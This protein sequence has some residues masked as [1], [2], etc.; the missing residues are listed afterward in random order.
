VELG[1]RE[2]PDVVDLPVHEWSAERF[3]EMGLSGNEARLIALLC[4]GVLH[5]S[6]REVAGELGR[7]YAA[8]RQDKTRGLHKIKAMFHLLPD[9][10]AVLVAVR[11]YRSTTAAAVRLEMAVEDVRRL[12]ASAEE[13]IESILG[14][15]SARKGRGTAPS[16]ANTRGES[17]VL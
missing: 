7:P 11:E 6:M 14:S 15:G 1:D 2:A 10:E 8:T 4:W 13:K 3:Q 9:E 17:D 12:L 5:R 16:G